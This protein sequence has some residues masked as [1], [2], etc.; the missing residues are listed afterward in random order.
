MVS[1]I[2]KGLIN[3]VWPRALVKSYV[4]LNVKKVTFFRI[5]YPQ[6]SHDKNN[7]TIDSFKIREKEKCGVED[8]SEYCEC[9]KYTTNRKGEIKKK[10]IIIMS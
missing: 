8:S 2:W 3:T 10:L 5:E 1:F 6:L 9:T 7:V 4:V